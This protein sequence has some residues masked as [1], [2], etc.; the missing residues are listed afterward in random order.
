[1]S[2]VH[3]VPEFLCCVPSVPSPTSE[4]GLAMHIQGVERQR[5]GGAIRTGTGVG[6][7]NHT[8]LYTILSL[9]E[10][11]NDHCGGRNGSEF[12]LKRTECIKYFLCKGYLAVSAMDG[13]CLSCPRLLWTTRYCSVTN[14]KFDI[15]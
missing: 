3:R 2:L 15:H 12:I 13:A 10:K 8:T 6:D 1:M 11:S 7:P 9:R 14:S 5:G 4:C